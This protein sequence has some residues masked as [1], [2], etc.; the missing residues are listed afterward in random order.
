LCIHIYF[1]AS[2]ISFYISKPFKKRLYKNWTLMILLFGL[3]GLFLMFFL[4]YFEWYKK[5]L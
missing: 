2:L 3:L 4:T 5:G 1:E